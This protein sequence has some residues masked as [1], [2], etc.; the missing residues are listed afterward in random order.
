MKLTRQLQA[1]L[2]YFQNDQ[3]DVKSE[4]EKCENV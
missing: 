4:K 3:L 1:L 2:Q